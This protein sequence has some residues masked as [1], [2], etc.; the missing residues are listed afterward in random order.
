[1]RKSGFTLLELLLSSL[2]AVLLTGG[3]L[4]VV[5]SLVKERRERPVDHSSAALLAAKRE[6]ER[7][8]EEGTAYRVRPGEIE[9]RT[10]RRL[11]TKGAGL[12]GV[13]YRLERGFLLRRE[14]DLTRVR[15]ISPPRMDLLL[16]GVNRFEVKR[17]EAPSP[18]A[19]LE[20]FLRRE[21]SDSAAAPER[22]P[23]WERIAGV[24]RVTIEAE[25]LGARTLEVRAKL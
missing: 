5:S 1:M 11:G 22:E 7:D 25:G 4:S 24:L 6:I 18:A 15:S 8:L 14:K 12:M 2:L 10:H 17:G 13:S 23:K 20:E 21:T 16:S 9:I 3:V 19:S